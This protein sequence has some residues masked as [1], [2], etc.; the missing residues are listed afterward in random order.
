MQK[1]VNIDEID[2]KILR[3]LIKDARASLSDIAKECEKSSVAVLNRIRRLK[4]LG[5]ITGAT[6]FPALNVLGFQIVATIGVE[7]NSNTEE[8]TEFFKN[9]TCLIEPAASI[10]EY[11]FCALV[12][13]E[14]I[15]CLYEKIEMLRMRFGIRKIIVNVW[16]NIPHVNYGNIVLNPMEK[17]ESNG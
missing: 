15:T 16:S 2:A 9:N 14:N 12:Y 5:V 17:D 10:G 7:A 4:K 1:N 13:A 11:D 3:M 8:I 6:I